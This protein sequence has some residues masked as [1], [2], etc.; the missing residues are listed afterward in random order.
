MAPPKDKPHTL[1]F[2]AP[3]DDRDE[4]EILDEVVAE[5]EVEENYQ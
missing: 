1:D 3:D 2:A 4:D 5:S